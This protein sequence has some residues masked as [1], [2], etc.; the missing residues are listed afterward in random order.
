MKLIHAGKTIEECQEK[1]GYLYVQTNVPGVLRKVIVK[2]EEMFAVG[3][4]KFIIY[5]E[6]AEQHRILK[7][8]TDAE[9]NYRTITNIREKELMEFLE[10]NGI[11]AEVE[12][13]DVLVN[14]YLVKRA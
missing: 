6:V 12:Y 1:V 4:K 8:L 10:E 2:P 14:T 7:C 3:K 9:R 5:D 13:D 11:R